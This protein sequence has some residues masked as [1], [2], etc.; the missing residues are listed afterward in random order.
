MKYID[1]SGSPHDFNKENLVTLKD[2]RG[3]HDLMKCNKCGIKGKR[4]TLDNTIEVKGSY[5]DL[6][7]N[8]CTNAVSES[9][10]GEKVRVIE[11]NANGPQF[12]NLLSGSEHETVASPME[13]GSERM[14]GVWVQGVG[15]P[16]KLLPGE[17]EEI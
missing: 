14:D 7:V 10:I 3:Q 1:M 13:E 2:R 6:K 12:A 9:T 5:S 16:V 4:R 11:C 17:Y 8:N 15:E